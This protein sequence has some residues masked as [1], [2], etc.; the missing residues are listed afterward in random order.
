MTRGFWTTRLRDSKSATSQLFGGVMCDKQQQAKQ[1]QKTT[2][3]QTNTFNVQV[4][5]NRIRSVDVNS[6]TQEYK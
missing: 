1:R 5:S 6:L 4:T 2:N 3:K